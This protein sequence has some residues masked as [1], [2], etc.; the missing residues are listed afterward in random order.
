MAVVKEYLIAEGGTMA[1]A[2]SR[3]FYNSKAW[4]I[5]RKEVLRRDAYTCHDCGGRATE[6]HHIVELT[7]NNID[8]WDVALSPDNLQS[9]CYSCHS[10]TTHK[11]GEVMDGFFFDEQ[12]QVRPVESPY[13]LKA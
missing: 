9:F 7:P 5:T 3:Q 13:N 6:V 11:T 10:K 4:L 2:F 12:G 8:V 1:K